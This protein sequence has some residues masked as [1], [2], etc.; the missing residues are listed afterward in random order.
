MV[1]ALNNKHITEMRELGIIDYTSK[2]A[3]ENLRQDN[4]E[5]KSSTEHR[6]KP[7]RQ[8][9]KE[10][11]SAGGNEERSQRRDNSAGMSITKRGKMLKMV[12]STESN[13]T[14]VSTELRSNIGLLNLTGR[15]Q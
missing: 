8:G 12:Y 13:T 1:K 2:T 15:N 4:C 3:H 9:E 6:V 7:W 11:D 10:E 5:F 14:E